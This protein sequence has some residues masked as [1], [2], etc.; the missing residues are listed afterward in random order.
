MT[1]YPIQSKLK[2]E[3]I[4]LSKQLESKKGKYMKEFR[5]NHSAGEIVIEDIKINILSLPKWEREYLE[6]RYYD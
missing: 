2:N 5:A 3:I 4:E 1:E 6:K